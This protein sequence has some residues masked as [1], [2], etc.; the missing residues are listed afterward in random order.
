MPGVTVGAYAGDQTA[1]TQVSSTYE[2][3]HLT[4]RE[5][6][7]IHPYIADGFVNKGDPVVI[8][9]AGVPTTYGNIVGVAFSSG[10][11]A[12]QMVTI[13]T[14]GIWNLTVYAEDDDGNRAIEFG[15]QLYI[16]AGALPGAA[17]GDGT[18][19]AE[20]SK[21]S[22]S[23]VQIPFG[24]ACGSLVAGGVGVIAVKV[25][26]E[27]VLVGGVADK[28]LDH[29]QGTPTNPIEWGTE[30]SNVQQV[31]LNVGVLTDYISGLFMRAFAEEDVPAG[32]I[33]GLIYSRITVEADSQ[34]MYAIRGRID[35]VM[36]TPQA[37][38]AN[39]IVGGM[40]SATL[41]N[42]GFALTLADRIKAL[43]VSIGQ[44]ATSTITTGSIC[45]IYVAMNGILTDNAGRT[46]GIYIYQGGGGSAYPD[47]G[48]H[49]VTE[50]ANVL[51]AI[52]INSLN[53]DTPAGIEFET[54][55]GFGFVSLLEY[56]GPMSAANCEYFMSFAAA[57]GAEGNTMILEA[58]TNNDAD[59]DFAIRVRLAGD[60]V[61]RV[62]RLYEA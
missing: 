1:G 16:R 31:I 27:I 25:H 32:G 57:A 22:N 46:A 40:F 54:S 6:E 35:L 50:S 43:D 29:V 17:D 48:I 37:T 53:V 21:I 14:E 5:D 7:L 56:D 15:D 38:I 61:D 41:D 10:L 20:I 19:D 59:A 2:G 30:G 18:G 42:A 4:A 44:T 8:C 33:Q 49:I 62:I 13:D 3:R 39:M 52:F 12:A 24:T 51:A 58:E 28:G 36:S 55:G 34:D 23:V 45:G 47:Y 11:P 60:G 26:K 9:D